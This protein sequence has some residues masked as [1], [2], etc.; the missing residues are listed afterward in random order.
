[1][2]LEKMSIGEL[3]EIYTI[4]K[5]LCGEYARMTDNYSL[6]TGDAKFEHLNTDMENMIQERQ[7]FFTYKHRLGEEIK[8]RVKQVFEDE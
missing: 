3:Y 1:M 2:K 4:V 5:D 6:A 7:R 8:N